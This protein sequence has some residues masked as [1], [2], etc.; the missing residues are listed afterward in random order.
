MTTFNT[1]SGTNLLNSNIVLSKVGL[2]EG[3]KVGDLGCGS[4][5]HFVFQAASIVGKTGKVFAIDIMKPVLENIN[6]RKR[7]EN[8]KNIE[9]IWSNL[10]IFNAT[11]I[12]SG[13]LDV[14]LLINILFQSHKRVEILR[15]AIRMLKRGGGLVVVEW[16]NTNSPFGPPIE[17]RVNKDLLLSVSEKIGIKQETEF[18]AGQ[19]HYGLIFTKT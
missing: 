17:E 14:A 15:E 5:G 2:A 9:T 1:S 4:N 8:I 10:E 7:L 18:F 11:K 12:E 16:K 19:Y 13:S 3:M 6:R